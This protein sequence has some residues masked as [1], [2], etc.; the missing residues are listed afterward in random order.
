MAADQSSSM[1]EVASMEKNRRDSDLEPSGM[2]FV[3]SPLNDDNYLV[4]SRAM[5]FALGSHGSRMKLSFIDGRS[6]RPPEGSDDLDEWIMKDYLVIT[7]ILNNVS[8][9]IVD[10]FMY[11]TSA[12]SLW[13]ELEASPYANVR[14]QILV[15]DPRPDVTKA[16][17]MLLNVKKELQVQ[18]LI[19]DTSK[20]LSFKVEHKDD[21]G[22]AQHLYHMRTKPYVDKRALHCEHCQKAGHT[23]ENYFRL[24]GTPEWYKELADKRKKGG[25]RGNLTLFH[26]GSWIV[27]TGAT[28]HDLRTK[29][30][31]AVGKLIGKL[32]ILDHNSFSVWS[33]PPDSVPLSTS[34][35]VHSTFARALLF[36]ASLP[37]RFWGDCVVTATYI[38]NRTPSHILN[39]VTPYELLFGKP[40]TYDHLEVF[41]CLCYATNTDPHKTKFSPRASKD[42]LFYE[43]TFSFSSGDPI[44]PTY[45]PIPLMSHST[46]D[47]CAPT[48]P[49]DSIPAP[50]STITTS[51]SQSPIVSPTISTNTSPTS[52]SLHLL[53]YL[54]DIPPEFLSNQ[55]PRSY[56]E[57]ASSKE[58]TEAM[59]AEILALERNQTWEITK[60]PPGKKAIGCKW[61]FRLKLKEDGT[62]DR[63]KARLVAKGYTQVEGVDY[64]ESF[65]PVAKAVTVRLLLA[66]APAQNWEIH[67]LD[68]NNAFLHGHL[69]EEIFMAPP[70][71]YQVAEGSVC[72]LTRS[73]YGLKQASRQ[74][75]QE[76]TSKLLRYGLQQSCHDHCLF[77]KGSQFDFVTLLVYVDDVLVVSP[78]L[79]LITAIKQHLDELFTIKDLGVA[80]YFLGLQIARST[81]GLLLLSLNISMIFSLILVYWMK[82]VS[83]HLCHRV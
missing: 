10:F 72:H 3:S 11:V 61:V 55:E 20:T 12:R 21:Q 52:I 80:R 14:S 33:K 8:K 81:A 26:S 2:I 47:A 23:K 56:K 42:V 1:V 45:C 37:E 73:L 69:D 41:G 57:A 22:T 77:T 60:L 30:N 70:E 44:Q 43:F 40:P 53:H 24:Y 49:T 5:R 18:I 78:S 7:W 83:P 65:S 67:Q 82:R 59:N 34:N 29:E 13:L 68:V 9:T 15:M 36:Q 38:I 50:S 4:W 51:T 48:S 25:G 62:V 71:G 31:L 28:R 75:N 35:I 6:V 46:I 54:L 79:N 74:W 58:W 16:F 76:F 66:V 27:D 63:Y 32:Y 64:V 39:W 17:A 19:P